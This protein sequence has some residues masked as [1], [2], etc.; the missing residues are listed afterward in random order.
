MEAKKK[1]IMFV[2]AMLLIAGF[3]GIIEGEDENSF[4][5]PA[6]NDFEVVK[7]GDDV[8]LDWSKIED[9][10]GYRVYHTNELYGDFPSGWDSANVNDTGWRHEDALLT[11]DS[12]YYIVRA[13]KNGVEGNMTP[14][15]F[16]VARD[17]VDDADRRL[18]Y[19]SIPGKLNDLDTIWAS[20]IVEDIEGSMETADNIEEVVRWNHSEGSYNEQFYYVGFPTFRWT[21]GEDFLIQPGDGIGIF[22]QT[23]ADFTWHICGVDVGFSMHFVDDADERLHYI[24]LPYTFHSHQGYE[25]LIASDIVIDIE[26]HTGDGSD[27][28]IE[29]VVKW[30]HSTGKYTEELYYEYPSGYGWTGG[31]DF[32]IEPGDGIGIVLQEGADFTWT[33]TLMDLIPPTVIDHSPNTTLVPVKTN[34]SLMF[35]R[36]MNRTS[37]EDALELPDTGIVLKWSEDDRTLTVSP[38]HPLIPGSK[39]VLTIA[40]SATDIRRN[41][42]DGNGDGIPG[43]DFVYSFTVELPPNIEHS[44]PVRWHMQDDITIEA[45]VTDDIELESV[46]LEYHYEESTD[47]ISMEYV[48]NDTF[49]ITLPASETET[50]LN[51]T[52]W[53]TDSSGLV[54]SEDHT[55][56]ILNLTAPLVQNIWQEHEV[57]PVNGILQ[58]E[59]SKPMDPD[60]YPAITLEP[61]ADFELFWVDTDHLK[62]QFYNLTEQ[63]EYTVHLDAGLTTDAYGIYLEDNL[64]YAFTSQG[65]PTIGLSHIEESS[66]CSELIIEAKILSDME[67]SEVTLYYNDTYG[68]EHQVQANHSEG[69]NWTATISRQERTGE[70]HYMFEAIDVIGVIGHSEIHSTLITNPTVIHPYQ[71]I[72]AEMATPFEFVVRITNPTGVRKVILHYND[73]ESTELSLKD[74]D[75]ADG[76]W[77]TSLIIDDETFE[78]QTEIIDWD[79]ESIVLPDVPISMDVGEQQTIA[80]GNHLWFIILAAIVCAGGAT[81]ILWKKKTKEAIPEDTKEVVQEKSEEE[82]FNNTPCTVCFGNIDN[83]PYQCSCG[84]IYHE[85][86]IHELGECPICGKD[87]F[88]GVQDEET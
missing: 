2:L 5:I 81:G 20:D 34:I 87:P 84:N 28:Y 23:N 55:V 22:V 41:R 58:L 67:I 19:V 16:C 78:Y 57:M 45:E 3:T 77:S 14:M 51:Y 17:F 8:V 82:Q 29:R 48:G 86:C 56:P 73:G 10:D 75:P 68:E 31:T 52:I 88:G 50:M 69:N 13:V 66:K 4:Y 61:E 47:N 30:D 40:S 59:F 42:L 74:G 71:D 76:N 37:V 11:G 26:G 72:E 63:T 33:P 64:S 25:Q 18:H 70:I 79:G 32:V 36:D 44:P 60:I 12:Y 15:G 53:A 80:F 1:L 24:S 38:Q 49:T 43:G 62:I 85:N 6:P 83:T 65:H 7:D 27:R 39:H 54:A 35:S 9:A 21:G 46:T